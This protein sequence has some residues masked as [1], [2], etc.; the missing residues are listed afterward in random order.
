MATTPPQ[1]PTPFAF[2]PPSP[3]SAP[4]GSS[5]VWITVIVVAGILLLVCI[6]GCMAFG[7]LGIHRMDA[8]RQEGRENAEKAWREMEHPPPGEPPAAL[9]GP[10]VDPWAGF[11]KQ[12]DPVRSVIEQ[13]VEVLRRQAEGLPEGSS[14]RQAVEAQLRAQEQMLESLKSSARHLPPAGQREGSVP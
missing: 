5:R 13:Q 9:P 6:G 12:A 10:S 2:P 3:P 7:L 1:P 4:S 14:Q 8:L 11:E